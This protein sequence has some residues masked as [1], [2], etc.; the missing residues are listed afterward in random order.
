MSSNS[1]YIVLGGAVSRTNGHIVGNLKKFIATGITSKTF[2]IGDPSNYTPVVVSFANVAIAGDLTASTTV[3]DHSN[4]GASTI[5]PS[6][7]VNRYWTL[8]NSGIV[9][10]TYS[11][12]F[13]F[14]PGDLDGG[15]NPAAFIVGKY[16]SAAWSY[17]TVGTRTATSTQA[18]GLSSFS[19]FQLGEVGIP[20]I[21]L[22]K[23]VNPN[24]DQPPDTDLNYTLTF[25]NSG[26]ANALSVVIIDPNPA[27]A[28]PAQR[29]FANVDY[30]LGSA[31]ISSP[32]T[33]TIEFSNDGGATWT[34]VP[35]SAGGGAPSGYDRTVT[36][37]RWSL[38]G[39]VAP[40]GSGSVSFVV[41]LQ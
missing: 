16:A 33:A 8:I 5:D 28:D 40:S 36:N 38:T 2:E 31:T 3:G 35:A 15:A 10:T 39:D 25:T 11:A 19:D 27:N 21:V 30:K 32:W 6:L 29:V 22:D 24:G 9:F 14:V 34:Y 23:S 12:T 1:I 26:T 13:N 20:A 37:I 18:T 4:I 41:R 17:P 7:S